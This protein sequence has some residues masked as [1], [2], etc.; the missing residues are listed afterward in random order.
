MSLHAH[1]TTEEDV[2]CLPCALEQSLCGRRRRWTPRKTRQRR[3][4]WKRGSGD[5][6]RRP[7]SWFPLRILSPRSSSWIKRGKGLWAWAL[8]AR[9]FCHLREVVSWEPHTCRGQSHGPGLARPH[10][11]SPPGEG[12]GRVWAPTTLA[13]LILPTQLWKFSNPASNFLEDS[14]YL[15][16][17]RTMSSYCHTPPLFSAF[18]HWPQIVWKILTLCY[19]SG[20]LP[21][22]TILCCT[23]YWITHGPMLLWVPKV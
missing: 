13:T 19:L 18:L 9:Q 23:K 12:A 3:S 6:R 2:Q 11:E 8:G 14:L 21:I 4:A 22:W 10:A 7:R 17:E 15:E 1:E 16:P 20:E 5:W